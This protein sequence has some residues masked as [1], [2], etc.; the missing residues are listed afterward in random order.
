MSATGNAEPAQP[1]PSRR[2]EGAA[3][4]REPL[5]GKLLAARLIASLATLNAD[6]SIHLVPMWFALDGEAILLATGSGSQKVRNLERDPRATVM[7]H[8][9]RPG[10]EVC[11][12]SLVGRAEV[13]RAPQAA[14][15][16]RRVHRRYVTECG[17]ALGP[18]REFLASDDVALRFRPE[19][20]LS[21]DERPSDAARALARSGG[22]APLEPTSPRPSWEH[23]SPP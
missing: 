3:V 20:A 2:S 10:F 9:S 8:D 1:T 14:E 17:A 16:V 15:L 12:V 18:V 13:V 7:V 6:G 4:L 23:G 19:R 22:A 5:A 21:W 11:G